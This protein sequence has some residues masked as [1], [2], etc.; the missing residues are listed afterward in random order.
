MSLSLVRRATHF[1]IE[2]REYMKTSPSM[3]FNTLLDMLQA[4]QP[5]DYCR[6]A[7][8]SIDAPALAN[9]YFG[10]V[11]PN[12]AFEVFDVFM[13]DSKQPTIIASS[14]NTKWRAATALQFTNL[15]KTALL[16]IIFQQTTNMGFIRLEITKNNNTF[17]VT[18]ACSTQRSDE[19]KEPNEPSTN[20][21]PASITSIHMCRYNDRRKGAW[22][23]LP[24]VPVFLDCINHTGRLTPPTTH[25]TI[26]L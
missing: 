25:R 2:Y 17:M 24:K 12:G 26:Q 14:L 16:R 7:T 1:P 20:D 4:V 15:A 10:A 3:Q 21:E 23:A 5:G 19:P 18:I 6:F 9:A 13:C 22:F 8:T 11:R